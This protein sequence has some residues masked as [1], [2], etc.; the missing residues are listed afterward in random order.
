MVENKENA[1]APAFED[2]S[3]RPRILTIRGVQ[4]VLD[5]DLAE[6]YGVQTKGVESGCQTE[7]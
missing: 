4:V 3:I 2:D 7:H 5:R 6:L 1:I